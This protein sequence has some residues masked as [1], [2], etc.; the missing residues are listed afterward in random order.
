KE[1]AD[2]AADVAGV[3]MA[4]TTIEEAP[5]AATSSGTGITV[6]GFV[7]GSEGTAVPQAAVTLISLGGSQ[8]GRAVAHADGAYALDAPSAGTYVLIGSADGFQ[9]QASTVVVGSEPVTYDMLLS[10]TSGLKGLVRTAD[11]GTAVGGAMVIVTDVRGDVLGTATTAEDGT[12]TFTELVP[13]PATV[14]VNANGFRPR[15]LPIE[16]GNTGVT[17]LDLELS[18][19]VKVTGVVKSTR[20]P[21]ADARVTL[22]DAAGN[23]VGSATTGDDGAYAFADLDG[24][25]YTVMATGYPPAATA[26]SVDGQG[27]EGHEIVLAHPSE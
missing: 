9:P 18:R 25:E 17:R 1:V 14:A 4:E 21:L 27:V 13:G 20:G 15:A 11:D 10:G 8:L 23:V 24:G 7:R 3:P 12:F 5:V 26:L 16:V 6:R 22:V 2:V 19:G